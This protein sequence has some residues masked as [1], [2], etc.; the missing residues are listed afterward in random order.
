[1][2]R[3][4]LILAGLVWLGLLCIDASLAQSPTPSADD[5][6]T[7]R[8]LSILF[9]G[10]IMLDGGPGHAVLRG[11]D[12]FADFATELLT[13]DLTIGNLECVIAREGRIA[14]KPYTFRGPSESLPWLQKYFDALSVAN[15]HTLDFGEAGFVGQLQLLEQGRLPSFGGGRNLAAARKPLL[16]ECRGR[17]IA[18]L[19]Y[20]GFRPDES[21]ATDQTAG[22]APLDREL[23]VA[24]IQ[25]A[26]RELSAEIVL[27]YLHWGPELVAQPEPTQIEL[28]R[29]LIDAGA[30]A[31]IG[32][33]PHVTQTVDIYRGKPIL[34]SLGNFVFDYYPG[35]P[36]EWIGWLAVLKFHT[37]GIIDLETTAYTIDL[38]GI[39]RK[40]P[41]D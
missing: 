21:S 11:V 41:V 27:P 23:M 25:L 31:V 26:R 35:D 17:R 19:G 15:N 16:L 36:E 13:A 34:Y 4:S 5:T 3:K 33:H 39:P 6:T 12:P 28:A 14:H 8:P 2:C 10:D 30:S 37:D 7:P 9:A 24:D 22:V 1:M 20:N 40:I 18:L 38:V 32:T 29:A